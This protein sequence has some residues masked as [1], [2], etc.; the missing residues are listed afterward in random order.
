M[1]LTQSQQARASRF[2][3]P[4]SILSIFFLTSS[5]KVHGEPDVA[6]ETL[7]DALPIDSTHT[8]V[9]EGIRQ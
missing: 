6:H 8:S 3:K 7:C 1:W 9:L 2:A 5:F 4:L